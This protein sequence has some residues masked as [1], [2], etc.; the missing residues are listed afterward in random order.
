MEFTAIIMHITTQQ[1]IGIFLLLHAVRVRLVIAACVGKL[2][3][4]G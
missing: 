2:K 4:Q 1:M 3:G